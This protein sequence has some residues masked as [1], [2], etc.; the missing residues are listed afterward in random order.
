VFKDLQR[1]RAEVE[2]SAAILEQLDTMLSASNASRAELFAALQSV[3]GHSS[4]LANTVATLR[5]RAIA[6][7]RTIARPDAA[8]AARLRELAAQRG[9]LEER[10]SSV[11]TTVEALTARKAKFS[12]QLDAA[13]RALHELELTNNRLRAGLAASEWQA[14]RELTGDPSARE[15]ARLKV[16]ELAADVD[17][18]QHAI[19]A[20]TSIMARLRVEVQM[21]GGRGSG[22][23]QLRR[24]LDAT[25]RDERAML[26]LTRDP[27]QAAAGA[28]LDALNAKLDTID[29]GNQAFRT[30]LDANVDQR[31]GG[32]R[33]T[34]SAE[35]EALAG[36]R[37]RLDTID[38]QAA[39][40][41]DAATVVALDRVRRDIA[42]IVLRADVGIVDTAFA[43]KQSETEQIGALERARAAAL[44]DLTQAYADLTRDDLP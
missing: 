19:D 32:V 34:I 10:I 12:N 1:S 3:V 14:Q 7:E 37:A 29:S 22:E 20:I 27:A 24:E 5:T 23:E 6:V 30:E 17:A 26:A 40:L 8:T 11:P 41:R 13:E 15:A 31:L 16:R 35:R 36:Y 25:L 4:S 42:H 18:H 44:T 39:G 43:R 2:E 9:E 38:Q 33:A 28:R 21:A